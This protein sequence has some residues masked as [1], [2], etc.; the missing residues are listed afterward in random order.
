MEIK[1]RTIVFRV[2]VS[3]IA[4]QNYVRELELVGLAQEVLE[5]IKSL[6]ERHSRK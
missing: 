6:L 3:K 1:T 2:L 5:C 4:Y